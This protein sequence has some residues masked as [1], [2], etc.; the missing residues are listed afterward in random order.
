MEEENKARVSEAEEAVRQELAREQEATPLIERVKTAAK[1]SF[2]SAVGKAALNHA[3]PKLAAAIHA[4]EYEQG[5]P[6]PP[7]EA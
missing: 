3:D 7:R 1:G 5:R 6:A 4:G 2:Y